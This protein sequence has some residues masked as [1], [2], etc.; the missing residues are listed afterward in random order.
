MP[1]WKCFWLLVL[2]FIRELYQHNLTVSREFANIWSFFKLKHQSD[3]VVS[4][5]LSFAVEE[6][7]FADAVI[8]V[9]NAQ[10]II[11]SAFTLNALYQALC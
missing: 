8:R 3:V 4:H 9:Y 5:N 10:G 7:R 2:L 11:H 6:S 1:S